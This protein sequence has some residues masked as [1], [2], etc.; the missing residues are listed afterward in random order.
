MNAPRRGARRGLVD[1]RLQLAHRVVVT[2]AGRERQ[3]IVEVAEP[4]AICFSRSC[5]LRTS[6]AN[7][8]S[9]ATARALD[10]ER[11]LT[12]RPRIISPS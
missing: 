6:S 1:A 11:L 5:S 10:A 7:A 8:A 3:D 12:E 9:R 2:F 4:A